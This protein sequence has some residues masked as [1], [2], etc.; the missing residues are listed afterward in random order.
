VRKTSGFDRLGPRKLEAIWPTI[1]D[2]LG[3][4]KFRSDI[5]QLS[6][7][8]LSLVYQFASLW[9]DE[10]LPHHVKL[11]WSQVLKWSQVSRK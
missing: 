8:E 5:F 11:N 3:R 1:F 7:K 9:E 2:Q 6:A 10:I 4:E